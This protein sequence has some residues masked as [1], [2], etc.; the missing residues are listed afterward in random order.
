MTEEMISSSISHF[1]S[2]A[3]N[4]AMLRRVD[5]LC[6][7]TVHGFICAAGRVFSEPPARRDTAADCDLS[8]LL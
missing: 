4:L 7:R 2:N 1:N 8:V 3:R 6:M 5:S